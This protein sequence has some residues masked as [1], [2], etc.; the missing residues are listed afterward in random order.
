[1]GYFVAWG[2]LERLSAPILAGVSVVFMIQHSGGWAHQ[3]PSFSPLLQGWSGGD[4]F[5]VARTRTMG[6][7]FALHA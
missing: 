2:L 7:W 5:R 3:M 4:V 6:L 1:M